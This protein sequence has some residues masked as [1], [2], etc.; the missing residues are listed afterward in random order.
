MVNSHS[1]EKSLDPEGEHFK[2]QRKYFFFTGCYFCSVKK[3]QPRGFCVDHVLRV[4]IVSDK[5]LGR[6]REALLIYFII[7]TFGIWYYDSFSPITSW[8]PQSS[9]KGSLRKSG[10]G[11]FR[12]HVTLPLWP[13]QMW[14]K[15]L[16][17]CREERNS[18]VSLCASVH[19]QRGEVN[20]HSC[21]SLSSG[22]WAPGGV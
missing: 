8:E 6:I 9:L 16:S 1:E 13:V 10:P 7:L 20:C 14:C 11:V 4:S 21:D 19:L 15:V 2:A 18:Q 17:D 22:S 12:S 3:N 5:L